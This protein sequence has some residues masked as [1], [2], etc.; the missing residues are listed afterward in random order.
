MNLNSHPLQQIIK[1]TSQFYT[2]SFLLE[3][4]N[5]LINRYT[6]KEKYGFVIIDKKSKETFISYIEGKKN[7]YSGGV[8][9]DVDGGPMFVPTYY[10]IENS[11][12]YLVGIVYPS[13]VKSHVLP[14]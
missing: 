6:Y 8:N 11:Y 4:N 5:F 10:F 14:N 2:P 9:N 13:Q 7:I 12:E 3:T 1:L